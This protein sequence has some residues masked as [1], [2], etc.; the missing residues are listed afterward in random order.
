[1]PPLGRMV[2]TALEDLARQLRF[3]PREALLRDIERAE[4]LA[5][6]IDP[7]GLYQEDW[8]VGQV[9]GYRPTMESPASVVGRALLA[10]LSAFVERLSAAAGLTPGDLPAGSLDPAAL[11][12][13]WKVS[14]KTL[15]RYRKRGLVAR[16]V[17][18][19]DAKVRLAFC[20]GVVA[21]FETRERAALERAA[22][23]SRIGRGDE[24]RMIRRAARYR[25]RFNCTL[26]EAAKRL[27][28]RF[29]RSHEAVR[30]VLRRHDASQAPEHRLFTEPGPP[31]ARFER[32]AWRAWRRGLDP[33]LLAERTGRSRASVVRSINQHRA[34]LLAVGLRGLGRQASAAGVPQREA[35]RIL[36]SAPVVSGLGGPAHADALA[37]VQSA[38]A[39]AAPLGVEERFRAQGYHLLVERARGVVSALGASTPEAERL[40]EAETMLRWAARLKAELVRAQQGL[41]LRTLESRLGRA[42][43]EVR[44][45]DLA[46]LVMLGVRAIGDAIDAHDPFAAAGKLPGRLAA[47]AGM[48]IDRAVARWARE[49]ERAAGPRGRALPRL[50]PGSPLPDW[51]WQVCVWQAFTEPDSRARVG[52]AGLGEKDREF[53]ARRFG[54]DGGPPATLDEIAPAFGLT[55]IAVVG[56]EREV[57]RAAVAAGRASM[58]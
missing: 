56:H 54:W 50:G 36:A 5:S 13:R 30:Q 8:I 21:A 39:A 7:D 23:F 29:G 52:L 16:R 51:T 24:Q 44:A 43:E 18:G 17:V 1:M 47:P 25:R 58:G 33:G 45:A 37:W 3:T 53:L 19:A 57:V 38:R 46:E 48:A 31:D 10:D 41:L 55:R 22:G 28:V 11:A 34:A 20:P 2:V 42:L 40:D 26:N 12:S 9:T 49:H 6:G 32:V 27:S 14:R 4:A 15:D 35:A